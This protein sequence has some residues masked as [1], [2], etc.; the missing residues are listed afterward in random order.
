M[1]LEDNFSWGIFG[2]GE[3]SQVVFVFSGF[4]VQL[5][6]LCK[7]VLAFYVGHFPVDLWKN[8]ACS[9]FSPTT[10]PPHQLTMG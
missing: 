1:E 3:G 7:P 9:S 2:W 10:F 5:S 8:D 4:L 6:V